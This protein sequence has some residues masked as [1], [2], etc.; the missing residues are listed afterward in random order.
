MKLSEILVEKLLDAPTKTPEQ[1]AKLH[2]VSVDD[3]QRELS[4]G[5]RVEMEHTSKDAVAREIALD[6]LA[7]DPRYYTKL[8]KV[9]SKAESKSARST[10]FNG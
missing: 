9:E 3:I 8:E 2:G 4:K 10:R 5:V 6:H 7:E 1:I